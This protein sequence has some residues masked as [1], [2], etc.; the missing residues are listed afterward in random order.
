MMA[1]QV[2][3]LAQHIGTATAIK[4]PETFK[5][6]AQTHWRMTQ[7]GFNTTGL[8]FDLCGVLES[9]QVPYET[10][11]SEA[12]G[13]LRIDLA[14]PGEKVYP[15]CLIGPH[16]FKLNTTF[17]SELLQTCNAFTTFPSMCR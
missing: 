16:D 8:V 2:D 17:L 4:L 9:L 7:L 14:L 1:M 15:V 10:G 5:S 11:L 3:L 12:K 13:L 6:Q